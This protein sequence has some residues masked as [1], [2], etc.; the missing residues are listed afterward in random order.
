MPVLPVA[1]G[2]LVLIH[3]IHVNG[4]VGDLPV[5]LGVQMQQGLAEFLQ[6]Q[7][8]DLAGENVCI[9]VMTPAHVSSVLASLNVLRISSL[10]MSVGFQTTS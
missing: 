8:H 9:Q 2:R 3:E 5:E 6:T 4:V 7:I 1:V 10:V